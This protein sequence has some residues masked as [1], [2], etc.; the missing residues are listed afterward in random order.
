MPVSWAIAAILIARL[1]SR[2]SPIA[3]AGMQTWVGALFLL[4]FA[5]R[6]LGE[7]QRWTAQA[8]GAFAFLVLG[9][10]CLGLVLYTWLYRDV[11]PTTVTLAQI[12]IP[13]QS[14]HWGGVHRADT[15]RRGARRRRGRAQRP[16]GAVARI[17]PPSQSD[18]RPTDRPLVLPACSMTTG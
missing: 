6:E 1:L 16:A 4:P 13:T 15:C 9:G 11:R 5:I 3:I 17:E 14:S 7:P 8:A 10:S 18:R 12:L 2:E